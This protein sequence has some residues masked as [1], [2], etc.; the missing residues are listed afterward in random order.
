MR[1]PFAELEM[2]LVHE[3]DIADV[4]TRVLLADGHANRHAG[5]RY[6]LTGP[7]ALTQAEQARRIGAAIGRPVRYEEVPPDVARERM[8]RSGVPAAFVETNLR[9]QAGLIGLPTEV[10][11]A[12]QQV[13]GRPAR[14]F[15]EWAAEHAADFR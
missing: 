12:I 9:F 7:E 13:T 14:T 8:V 10:S 15:D 4:A 1:G 11:P 6:V 3:R 2:A 5:A